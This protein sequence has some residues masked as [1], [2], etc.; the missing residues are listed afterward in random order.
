M[1]DLASTG[2]VL[3]AVGIVVIC[4]LL[5]LAYYLAVALV[6]APRTVARKLLSLVRALLGRT[7]RI[8]GAPAARREPARPSREGA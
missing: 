6:V 1:I 7:K 5:T 4:I 3:H 8:P 2:G